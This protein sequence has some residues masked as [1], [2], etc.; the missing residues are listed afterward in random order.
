MS[1]FKTFRIV[2]ALS[3]LAPLAVFAIGTG[4][5]TSGS[6]ASAGSGNA[7][8]AD[9]HYNKGVTLSDAKNYSEALGE[10]QKAVALRTDFAEA[11]NMIG[12]TYRMLGKLTLSLQNYEKALKLQPDFP[13]AHEYLGET[14]LAANDLLHAMQNYLV[15]KN[16]GRPE[17][18]ELWDKIVD[19]VG[20]KAKVS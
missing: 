14:Y 13:Q 20:T 9:D 10:F 1:G 2:L 12:F 17:A 16:A 19:F 3:L 5:S 15:L 11:Y 7:L 18:Q 4:P 6:T 8:T